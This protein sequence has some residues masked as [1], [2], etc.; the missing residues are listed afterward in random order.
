MNWTSLLQPKYAQNAFIKGHFFVIKFIPDSVAKEVFNLGVGFIEENKNKISSRLLDPSLRGFACIYGREATQE[1]KTLLHSVSIALNEVGYI[2]PPSPQIN[3]TPLVPVSGLSVDAIMSSLYRDYIHMD[4]YQE[5]KKAKPSILNTS[6]LRKGVQKNLSTIKK[7]AYFHE[8]KV[9]LEN[10]I[11]SGKME[12]DLPIWKAPQQHSLFK[13]NYLFASIVSA[14]YVE[15]DSLSFN[16]DYLGSR[17]IQNACLLTGRKAKAGLFIYRPSINQ[18]I[19]R[20]AMAIIDNHIDTSLYILRRMNKKNGYEIEI[21]V[22]DSDA[23]MYD[24]VANFIA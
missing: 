6:D 13:D 24:R 20:E 11:A 3:Y 12:L 15:P 19:T 10:D 7:V 21:D 4:H 17:N 16:L 8:E 1:L 2:S 23:D 22:L 18:R 14:D 5:E 9:F